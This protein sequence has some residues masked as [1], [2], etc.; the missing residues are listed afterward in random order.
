M[1]LHLLLG[2]LLLLVCS[3]F[4]SG[5]ETAIFS[6]STLERKRLSA[7][8][9]RR[10]TWV[11]RL[12]QSPERT[13]VTILI[14]NVLV[15]TLAFVLITLIT[16]RFLGVRWLGFM[17]ALFTFVLLMLGEILPKVYAVRRNEEWAA[18]AAVPL[19]AFAVVIW[20]AR[21]IV[22]FVTDRIMNSLLRVSEAG[23]VRGSVSGR[24]LEGAG[25][26]AETAG[27][28]P[29]AVVHSE[30]ELKT[31]VRISAE[32]GVLPYEETEMIR[33]LLALGDRQ[34]KEIMTPRTQIVR[35]DLDDDAGQLVETIRKN[36]VSFIPI[37]QKSI[38]NI[39][40]V[41][42]AEKFM[43]SDR[44]SIKPL[45]EPAY[46]VPETKRIDELF[47]EFQK[48]KH[49]VAIAVDEHGGTAGLVTDED[50]LEEIFGEIYDEYEAPRPMVQ[51]IS[52][53]EFVV[54]AKIS[55]REFNEFFNANLFSESEE[56][57][58]GFLLERL[59]HIPAPAEQLKQDRWSF[60]ILSVEHRRIN[61]VRVVRT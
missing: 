43:L 40:G 46:F 52:S 49:D 51:K 38:D 33:K 35:F 10:S 30:D 22:R 18:W 59:G 13:L 20:P 19:S 60:Y 14:G 36:H 34:V 24:S 39:M 54:D 57:L 61:Q 25:L 8:R 12:I 2:I 31:L 44:A 1:A 6:L 41:L 4:F 29:D 21:R 56:T 15:N 11:E 9:S 55:L 42:S 17:M 5:T 28:S 7:Q 45:I 50:I 32:E 23:P 16:L 37:Y 3:A 58:A 53:N 47:L 27:T 48:D 26:A